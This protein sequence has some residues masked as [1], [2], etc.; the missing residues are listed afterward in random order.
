MD[1]SIF[2]TTDALIIV[3]LVI[4]IILLTLWIIRIER[5]LK[6]LLASKNTQTIDETLDEM[7]QT[8]SQLYTFSRKADTHLKNLEKRTQR[9]IQSIELQR[10][11]PF[12]G[13]GSGGTNSFSV[14]FLNEHGDGVVIS[15]M[16]T[17]ER[18]NVFSKKLSKLSSNQELSD[19]ESTVIN[20]AYTQQK[21][22]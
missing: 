8:I 7:Q 1:F 21:Q 17:R 5:K 4:T 18:T 19:E 11:N 15:S 9:S 16:Y 22:L 3:F 14:A 10:Y 13:D 20:K 6:I 12:S 2:L